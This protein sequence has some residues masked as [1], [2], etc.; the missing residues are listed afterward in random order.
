MRVFLAAVAVTAVIAVA[1]YFVLNN[2]QKPAE[3]TYTSPTSVRL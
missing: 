1:S 3:L 2:F